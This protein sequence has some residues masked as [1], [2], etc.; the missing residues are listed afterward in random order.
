[1]LFRSLE[2][3]EHTFT[4]MNAYPYTSGHV[5]VL[6]SRHEAE[7][8][9]LDPAEAAAL[10]LAA[11]RAARVLETVYRPEGINLG[12]NVGRAAG[13][14]VPEHLH[15]H[16]VPRWAGDSNFMTA[17]AETRVLPETLEQS[18]ARLRDGFG[19]R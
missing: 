3:D 7:L 11:Q 9:A 16:L 2:R 14:G 10:M 4:I 17:V 8:T 6:P 19:G 18:Y 15:L 12:I 1:M 5:M 13:A